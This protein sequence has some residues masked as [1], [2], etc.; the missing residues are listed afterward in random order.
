MADVLDLLNMQNYTSDPIYSPIEITV[1]CPSYLSLKIVSNEETPKIPYPWSAFLS[2]PVFHPKI[3]L[4]LNPVLFQQVYQVRLLESCL[5]R[6]IA[7]NR[8][9]KLSG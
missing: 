8:Y 5:Q 7:S 6:R 9:P 1:D 4:I 3:K 2:Q